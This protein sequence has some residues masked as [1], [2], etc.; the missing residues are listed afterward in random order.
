MVPLLPQLQSDRLPWQELSESRVFPSD[1][2]VGPLMPEDTSTEDSAELAAGQNASCPSD[3]SSIRLAVPSGDIEHVSASSRLCS[4]GVT[5]NNL[6][7]SRC[8]IGTADKASLCTHQTNTPAAP[9]LMLAYAQGIA[10]QYREGIERPLPC[11]LG[12]RN[13]SVTV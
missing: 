2:L 11:Q 12:P 3:A 10:E 6:L 13:R 8:A 7:Q 9:L 4:S 1:N 5:R